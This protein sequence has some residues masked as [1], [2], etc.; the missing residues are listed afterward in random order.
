MGNQR[1]RG[2]NQNPPARSAKPACH[3]S[4]TNDAN[5]PVRCFR[6]LLSHNRLAKLGKCISCTSSSTSP[7]SPSPSSSRI[8]CTSPS[9][10]ALPRAQAGRASSSTPAASPAAPHAGPA[11]LR[12]PPPLRGAPRQGCE[13]EEHA[14]TPTP[15]IRHRPRLLLPIAAAHPAPPLS[16]T[17]TPSVYLFPS[18]D[19]HSASI[20]SSRFARSRINGAAGNK[21]AG[22]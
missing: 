13:E 9:T 14:G 4:D 17:A 15:R 11:P 16:T 21:D 3:G 20:L 5:K 1:S 12:R 6:V 19:F 8:S 18:T 10:S 22:M 7:S 2:S